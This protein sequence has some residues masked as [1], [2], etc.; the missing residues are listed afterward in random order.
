MQSP[1]PIIIVFSVYVSLVLICPK[2][3]NKLP[4]MNLKLILVPYNFVLVALS[5]YM[6]VEVSIIR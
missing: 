1:V 5:V 3:V 4:P 2:L 6:C